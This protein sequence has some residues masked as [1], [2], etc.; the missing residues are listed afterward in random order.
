MPKTQDIFAGS[1]SPKEIVA[2]PGETFDVTF[3]LCPTVDAPGT[4]VSFVLPA[5][6]VKLVSG[7]QVWTGDLKEGESLT[8]T[9]SLAANGEVEAYV[10]ADVEASLSGRDYRSSYYLQVATPNSGFGSGATSDSMEPGSFRVVN[11]EYVSTASNPVESR[12]TENPESPPSTSGTFEV[13]GQFW[14]A[15]EAGGW[16]VARYMLA[17]LRDND[18]GSF[19]ATQWTDGDGKFDFVVANTAGKRSPILDLI[20]EGTW[21]WK[22][23]TDGGGAQYWWS[24]GVIG[25]DVPDGW[26]YNNVN[27]GIASNSETLQ[28]GDAVFLE[29]NWVYWMS[30]V[31]WSRSKVAIWFPSGTWPHSHGDHIDLPSKSTAGWNHVTV[32]H[33]DG[34][35]VMYTLWGN[36][37]PSTAHMGESH[38]VFD[39]KDGGFAMIEGWAEFMQCAVD[40]NPANLADW[41]NGHGGNI[42]TND[43]FNCRDTGDMD[44]NIIEGSIASI[45]WDILDPQ[46]TAG[47]NDYLA[48]DYN[49]IFTVMQNDHPGDMLAFWNDW[50]ARWPT[51]S[52]SMGPLCSIYYHYGIDEDWFNPWGSITINAGATYTTSRT[53]TLTLDGRDWGV[54]VQYMR[55]SEDWGAN[56][57]SWYAYSPTFTYTIQSAGDGYKYIDVQFADYWW[58]SNGGTIYDGIWLDTT[59]PTGTV[60]IN[61]GAT[62]TTSRTVT[63]T[64]SASDATSGVAKVRFSENLGAWT[65]WYTYATSFSC[66]LNSTNDGG[67]YI[68][69][70]LQDYAGNPSPAWTIWDYIVLD[71]T[72][73]TGSIVINNG[74]PAY[75]NTT[76][77][78]LYLTYSDATS[79]VYQVRYGNA[80]GYWEAWEAPAA[81]K[82]W[83]LSTGDGGKGV[84][85]EVMDNAGN[86]QQF[87]DGITLDTVAPTSGSI[88]I[89]SGATYTTSRTVTLTLY[90]SDATSGVYQMRFS[91]NG[92]AWGS[93]VAYATTYS[94]TLTSAGDGA[95]SVDV[96]F[97]DNAHN[98][99]TL[100]T[101]WDYIYLDT[102]APTGS[103]VINPGNPTYTQTTSVTL[104]LTYSDT[105]SGVYQVRYSNDG[106]W[107][108]EPWE[109]PAATKAWTLTAGNGGKTVYYQIKDNAGVISSTYS[110]SINLANPTVRTWAWGGDTTVNCVAGADVDGDGHTEIVTGG[111]YFDG[112]R[113]VALLQVWDGDTLSIEHAVPWY[114]GGNTEVNCLAVGDVDGDGAKEIV[115]G[116]YY[117]DGVRTVAQLHVWNGTTMAVEKVQTWYWGGNTTIKSL[118]IGDVDADGKL[119][120]VTG[121]YYYDGVRRVALLHVWNG[122]TLAVKKTQPWYWGSNTEVNSL[123]L[124]DVDADGFVEIVTGGYYYDGVRNVAQLHVWNGSNLAVENVRTWYWGGSTEISSLC[125]GDVDADGATEVVTGGFYFDGTRNVAL[126]H[127]WSGATLSVEHAVPW[128]WVG[129][130]KVLAVAAGDP[131]NDGVTE[132]VTGGYYFDG[133]REVAQLHVWSGSSLAVESVKT[134]YWG[135]STSV[136]SLWIGDVN[137]DN[138]KEMVTGG[139]YTYGSQLY[140]QLMVWSP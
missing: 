120:I 128:F 14:F 109:A 27:L 32:Q 96:Q 108:T 47:D 50:A 106:V 41:Y 19:S 23:T 58:L 92:A 85:Y 118:A 26:V 1:F 95:K 107:D 51:N 121:G 134:W 57:G 12:A 137:G 31:Y 35:C 104:Y 89:N 99:T 68:D 44:G 80:G 38:Y 6:L 42:E 4:T 64:L 18:D 53:V 123:A 25:W 73:P 84:W 77:V 126:L 119:E 139:Y 16:S 136:K 133:T 60:S 140:A 87:Y 75:T 48:W 81:T 2:V 94:F 65:Q 69:I 82:A 54:G 110:D 9:L 129:D 46:N 79:G 83:T 29:M 34:H 22:A 124:G 98:P 100:W 70:Q 56:W 114:W 131:D 20:A 74:N 97:I 90:A 91:E 33:E 3:S 103:I 71:T 45:L 49:E 43:W 112:V 88:S 93:W 78:T 132:I 111:Y 138:Y 8:L 113:R 127:V 39:E 102:T 125:L 62:Y 105:L 59:P 36:S 11:L 13:K 117:F 5:D 63:L 115:T 101:I 40:N 72:A 21:D 135:G 116:G 10:K 66:L 86:S 61:S 130:T 15:D 24:T 52:T 122:A 7:N 67:K 28:A 55:F 17:R 30:G 37:W 76:S